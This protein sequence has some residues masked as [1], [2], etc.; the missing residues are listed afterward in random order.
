MFSVPCA[1]VAHGTCYSPAW[2]SLVLFVQPTL[3]HRAFWDSPRPPG[4]GPFGLG[5]PGAHRTP[6]PHLICCPQEPP[7]Q[8]TSDLVTLFPRGSHP[9]SRNVQTG[10]TSIQEVWLSPP[11]PPHTRLE[12]LQLHEKLW[13]PSFG[14]DDVG[15]QLPWGSLTGSGVQLPPRCPPAGPLPPGASLEPLSHVQ[16]LPGCEV[17]SCT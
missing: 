7:R 12:G 10:R 9:T 11:T 5:A 13:R 2:H 15:P 16:A 6:T 4:T 17:A 8:L 3:G 14:K 1:G